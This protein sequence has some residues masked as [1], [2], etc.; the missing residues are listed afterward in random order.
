MKI[1][2]LN[3]KAKLYN[4]HSEHKTVDVVISSGFITVIGNNFLPDTSSYDNKQLIE[5]EKYIYAPVFN[6]FSNGRFNISIEYKSERGTHITFAKMNII[7]RNKL[8]LMMGDHILV[9][10][11][12]FKWFIGIAITVALFIYQAKQ[13]DKLVEASKQ[14]TILKDSIHKLQNKINHNIK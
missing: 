14:N 9:K 4:K 10:D 3:I 6:E 1:K 11:G 7:Q 12:N 5:F 13:N 2:F 8:L